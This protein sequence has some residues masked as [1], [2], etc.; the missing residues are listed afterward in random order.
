[1]AYQIIKRKTK[2]SL[3]Y[4]R[5]SGSK[6]LKTRTIVLGTPEADGLGVFAGMALEAAQKALTLHRADGRARYHESRRARLAERAQVRALA[7]TAWLPA[8]LVREFE[9]ER[10][11]G[12]PDRW[13]IVKEILGKL[14]VPPYEWH[15]QP[16]IF[17]AGF[18]ARGWSLGY[19][20]KLM[21]LV[22]LW[23][24]FYC[25]RTGKQWYPVPK[26]T[27][28]ARTRIQ[29]K[30]YEKKANRPTSE[31][32]V[33]HLVAAAALLTPPEYNSLRL[34]FWCLLRKEELA[35]VLSNPSSDST[36]YVDEDRRGF[37]VFHVF[38]DKLRRKGIEPRL[39]WKAVPL[40]E[41]EQEELLP[42]IA[43]AAFAPVPL[44]KLKR[45]VG[46]ALTNRSA[47]KGASIELEARGYSRECVNDWL[48]HIGTTTAAKS[49]RSRR[50]ALWAPPEVWE[51]RKKG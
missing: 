48:G 12:R 24:E 38:Q 20:G 30:H 35:F 26:P 23:G 5:Y 27:G 18:R 6:I 14:E 39:C 31:M 28:A 2:W 4:R 16:E 17:W 32:T 33:E 22:N 7:T 34:A 50:L 29:M 21:R 13:L 42:V 44:R 40:V 45:E 3:V 9:K 1:M 49:Y 19:V 46:V 15:W 10:M 36:W 37:S 41:P 8:A 47:R 11:E 51:S 43:S 25:R